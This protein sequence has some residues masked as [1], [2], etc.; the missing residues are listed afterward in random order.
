MK[1]SQA[2]LELIVLTTFVS[3]NDVGT[4]RKQERDTR[5]NPGLDPES[6]SIS[7]FLHRVKGSIVLTYSEEITRTLNNDLPEVSYRR[8]PDMEI[9]D[10]GTDGANI[11]LRTS[12]GRPKVTCGAGSFTGVTARIADCAAKNSDKAIWEGFRYGSS[13]EGTW[14]LVSRMDTGKE[15][16]MDN[17]TGMVWSDTV[18]NRES[19]ATEFDWCKASGNDQ[20]ATA[21]MTIDC[22][23][24]AAGESSCVNLVMDEIGDQIQ[25][26]LPTRN[27]FLQADL[28]GARFV[29]KKENINGLWTATMKSNTSGRNKAWIYNSTDGTLT[30]GEL[31]TTRQVKCIG[32]PKL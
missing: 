20:G 16:W 14:Q 18:V 24:Q 5:T 2:L 7:S 30:S 26:R 8:V 3:C 25:W 6:N 23:K 19:G 12:L 31:T 9:D 29:L 22:T 17:R 1:F 13:G 27:D 11:T 21:T 15:I 4:N 10:E 28:D 32:T